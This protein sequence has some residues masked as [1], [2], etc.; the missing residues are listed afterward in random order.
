MIYN[1]HTHTER[2]G[3]AHGGDEEFINRAI[4]AGIKY[5][6]FSDHIPMIFPDGYESSYRVPMS[7][8]ESYVSDLRKLR[9]KHRNKIEI[10]IG[11]EMEYYA[12]HFDKMLN[13][14]R[15]VGAEYLILGQHF[16]RG[17]HPDGIGSG[18]PTDNPEHLRIYTDEVIEAMKTGVFSYVAHPD[19]MA[20][21]GD[22][23]IYKREMTRLCLASRKLNIPL[24]I[25]L[26]GVRYNKFYPADEFWQIAGEVGAPVT[27]GY[28]A[29]ACDDMLNT[30]QLKVAA[31]LIQRCALNY[32]GMPVLRKI[33]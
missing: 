12:E 32:V 19:L 20:F 5:L 23:E 3:H 13:T 2:C 1:Y 10:S 8:A 28:D 22:K 31:E 11:F 30:E 24:E 21:V 18:G 15:N 27:I 33:Q 26:G 4:E 9:E 17:E 6:G 16:L 14:A 29:H 25:N 7:E